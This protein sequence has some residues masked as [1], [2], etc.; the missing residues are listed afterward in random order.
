VRRPACRTFGGCLALRSSGDAART[1]AA[2][3]RTTRKH[4]ERSSDCPRQQTQQR[5]G[6]QQEHA[7]LGESRSVVGSGC[8]CEPSPP[9]QKPRSVGLHCFTRGSSL[10]KHN[11]K[12]RG[13]CI[14]ESRKLGRRNRQLGCDRREQRLSGCYSRRKDSRRELP[15]RLQP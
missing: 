15:S 5:R 13:S 9:F 3:A 4:A 12:P 10:V 1:A 6:Q 14:R 2:A 7:Q 8:R 11:R